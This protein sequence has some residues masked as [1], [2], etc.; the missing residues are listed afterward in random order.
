MGHRT[1]WNVAG[2]VVELYS[3]HGQLATTSERAYDLFRTDASPGIRLNASLGLPRDLQT[4]HL[5]FECGVWSLHRDDSQVIL[6]MPSV[7]WQ[8][9]P[10]YLAV[11]TPEMDAGRLWVNPGEHWKSKFPLNR[12]MGEVLFLNYMTQHRAGII[13]HA[14]GIDDNGNGYLFAGVSGAG[15][16]TMSRLWLERSP[17]RLLNDDRIIVRKLGDE[18]WMFSTP[19]HGEE[20]SVSAGAVP[21]AGIFVIDHHGQNHADSL[22]QNEAVAQL[23]IRSFP[24]YWDPGGMSF[25]VGFLSELASSVPCWSLGFVPDP[26]AVDFARCLLEL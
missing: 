20:E 9:I 18:F 15:K 17:A 23:L 21:L 19:W 13:L 2:L 10:E 1:A 3:D 24:T 16:T 7:S 5:V 12:P 14:C 8:S 6:R 26:T 25:A 4:P 22:T 11:L